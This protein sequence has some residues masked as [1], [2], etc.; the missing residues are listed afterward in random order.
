MQIDRTIANNK[1]G[2]VLC[3]NEKWKYMLV[4]VTISGDRNG[5]KKAAENITGIKY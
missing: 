3:D 5:V 1:P 4:D 2:I